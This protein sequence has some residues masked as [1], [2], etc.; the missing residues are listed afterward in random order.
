MFCGR[1]VDGAPD[2]CVF[3]H[4]DLFLNQLKDQG[5]GKKWG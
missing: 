1:T 3:E 4:I 5:E 2:I